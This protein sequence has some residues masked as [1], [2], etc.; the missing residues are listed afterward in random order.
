[1]LESAELQRLP[2]VE[3]P[4]NPVLD[5]SVGDLYRSQWAGIRSDHLQYYSATGLT[6][7]GLGLAVGAAVANTALDEH[8][9]RHEYVENIMFAPGDEL[10]EFMHEPKIF[11]DASYTLPL[12]ALAAMSEPLT[13]NLP[14]G[15]ATA[16]W[17]QR[18]FRT[19]LVGGPPV[20]ALQV[21]TG[22][23]RPGETAHESAWRPLEDSNGVS[24][25]GFVGAVPFLSL[26]EMSQNPLAK[27]VWYTTSTLPALS[28]V[29]DD[30]HYFS[31][32]ALGWY[33]AFLAARAVDRTQDGQQPSHLM[34]YPIG[35]GLGIGW[36][37]TK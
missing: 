28:R 2:S 13:E 18:S 15:P 21:L 37:L 32:A 17:G 20:L 8:F 10:R 26:A 24:G 36:Q 3:R 16:E 7:L 34:I 22:G 23:S 5:L 14:M 19:L 25:H 33:L 29:N 35:D 4:P 30:D 11:G 1:M 12:Y 31:Q 9:V 6:Q 27:G